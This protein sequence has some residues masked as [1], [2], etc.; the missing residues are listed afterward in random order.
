VA[1]VDAAR[2]RLRRRRDHARDPRRRARGGAALR[3]A[4][5]TGGGIPRPTPAPGPRLGVIPGPS[6]RADTGHQPSPSTR[7]NAAA[8]TIDIS[9]NT[10]DELLRVFELAWQAAAL[11]GEPPCSPGDLT[12]TV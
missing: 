12:R 10:E 7:E 8:A 6:Y 2:R 4:A 1:A 9:A 3:R 11:P 5:G